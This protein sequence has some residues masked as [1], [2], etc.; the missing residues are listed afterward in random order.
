M[1]SGMLELNIIQQKE[2]AKIK[3]VTVTEDKVPSASS[4]S[5]SPLLDET[6]CFQA[7]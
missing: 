4:T 7:H 6:P 2:G 1:H 3:S 5:R